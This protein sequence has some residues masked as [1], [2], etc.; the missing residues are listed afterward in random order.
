MKGK[1]FSSD[2]SCVN[3]RLKRGAPV[4]LCYFFS[5]KIPL[6]KGIG[7]F[8]TS[9]SYSFVCLQSLAWKPRSTGRGH[10]WGVV[11]QLHSVVFLKFSMRHGAFFSSCTLP[12]IPSLVTDPSTV[13]HS[14]STAEQSVHPDLEKWVS[15]ML[16]S[17]CLCPLPPAQSGYTS[18]FSLHGFQMH[19]HLEIL[20]IHDTIS[21]HVGFWWPFLFLVGFFSVNLFR[22]WRT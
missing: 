17:H 3:C 11:P 7:V 21:F 20:G 6:E 2:S 15:G 16:A 18:P 14:W 22:S 19:Q 5:A 10:C 9:V 4:S 12:F 1:F 8:S 13:C